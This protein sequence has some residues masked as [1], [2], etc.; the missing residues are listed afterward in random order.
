MNLR[1]LTLE[2]AEELVR[3]ARDEGHRAEIQVL[4]VRAGAHY[5]YCTEEAAA[6]YIEA[7]KGRLGRLV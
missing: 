7:A 5:H 2:M 4:M 3:L 6:S 1:P